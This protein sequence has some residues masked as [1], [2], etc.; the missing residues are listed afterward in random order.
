MKLSRKFTSRYLTAEDLPTGRLPV[1]IAEF[2]E[3][4]MG[5]PR[6]LKPVA[7]FNE[8]DKGLVVKRPH[9]TTLQKAF[10]DETD[11]MIG[12]SIDLVVVCV[13]I[14]GEMRNVVGIEVPAAQAG[15]RPTD[16]ELN[17]RLDEEATIEPPPDN[18]MLY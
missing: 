6:E 17:R 13:E 9:A 8:I 5:N 14:N 2:R 18:E 1:T 4:W 7:Y 11:D 10:G 15:R 16:A 12:Q 3:E